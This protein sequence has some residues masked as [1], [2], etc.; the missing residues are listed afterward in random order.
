MV[1]DA[2]SL[3]CFLRGRTGLGAVC[4][5]FSSPSPTRPN[6]TCTTLALSPGRHRLNLE[7][8]GPA[9]TRRGQVGTLELSVLSKAGPL[10]LQQ[11]PVPQAC[12]VAVGGVS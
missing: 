4:F 11:D 10:L 3:L 9:Q 1:T 12:K 2:G 7:C 6:Q 5:Q 8:G